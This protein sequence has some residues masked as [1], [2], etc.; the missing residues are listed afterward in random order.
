MKSVKP[1]K[2]TDFYSKL[3][4]ELKKKTPNCYISSPILNPVLVERRLE[5]VCFYWFLH[6]KIRKNISKITTNIIDFLSFRKGA[7]AFF[8][9]FAP[10]S[11]F[12]D[13]FLRS[14][15]W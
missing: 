15:G 4:T 14:G 13:S 8:A 2:K 6:A 1:M 7:A 12:P 3:Y 10:A 5:H 11:L 9:L